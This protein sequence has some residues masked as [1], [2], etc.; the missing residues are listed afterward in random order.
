M[1]FKAAAAFTLTE[2]LLALGILGVIAT[3]TIPKVIKVQQNQ[4]YAAAY[5]EA[6]ST[7]A[8]AYQIYKVSNSPVR[9]TTSPQDLLP[10]L[11]YVRL[12]SVTT[13]DDSYGSASTFECSWGVCAELHNGGY[14]YISTGWITFGQTTG[15]NYIYFMFDP[16]GRYN[17]AATANGKSFYIILM[18]NGRVISGA[19]RLASYTTYAGGAPEN[20]GP[21][22]VPNW[23][24]WPP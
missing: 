4:A 6:M 15:N 24:T 17:A 8:A 11:N 14:L 9:A 22:T 16:D 18:Y 5:K 12:D 19:E 7:V 20:N 13:I 3:Y 2:L 21:Q 10:Y 23:I 1:R